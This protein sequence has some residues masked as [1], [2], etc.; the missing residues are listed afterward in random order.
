M[1]IP[2]YPDLAIPIRTAIINNA[3]IMTNMPDYNGN[4]NVFSRRPIPLDAPSPQIVIGPDITDTDRGGLIDQRL[5]IIR[6]IAIYGTNDTAERYRLTEAIAFAVRTL[7]HRNRKAIT[8]SGW[9]VVNIWAKGP[10][11]LPVD[12]PD[13]DVARNVR[14]TI[15]LVA[16]SF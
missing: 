9:N 6:D 13:K 12:T 7:F 4:D 11:F 8:V 15:E 10:S 14:L 3:A 5:S 2:S 16:A 1:A